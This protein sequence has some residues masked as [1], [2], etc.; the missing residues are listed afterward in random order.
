M[1][2]DG[3]G[4][5]KNYKRARDYF[6]KAAD[7][8]ERDAAQLAD[9]MSDLMKGIKPEDKTKPE[10]KKPKFKDILVVN[11]DDCVSCA[12]CED[13]CPMDAIKLKAGTGTWEM[14]VVDQDMCIF[15]GACISGC[16]V[17]AI[18]VETVENV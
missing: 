7:L 1:Y 4:V 8:G 5:Q 3:R 13:C 15:C 11:Y 12:A 6:L 16:P 2:K 10:K 14:P 9:E 17:D 18:S